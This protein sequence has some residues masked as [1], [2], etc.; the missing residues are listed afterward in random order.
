MNSRSF[1][2]IIF[3]VLGVRNGLW[4]QSHPVSPGSPPLG[5]VSLRYKFATGNIA[6]YRMSNELALTTSTN[7]QTSVISN[8]VTGS[9]VN[10]VQSV[11]SDGDATM[12]GQLQGVTDTTTIDGQPLTMPQSSIDKLKA[13][14][15]ITVS[16]GGKILSINQA[17]ATAGGPASLMS[18]STFFAYTTLP[19]HPVKINDTWRTPVMLPSLPDPMFVK[20]A[21][22]GIDKSS[23]ST[24]AILAAKVFMQTS[25]RPPSG[26]GELVYMTLT[27]SGK[28]Y[29]DVNKGML[30]DMDLT[31]DADMSTDA[32]SRGTQSN[33]NVGHIAITVAIK[34]ISGP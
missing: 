7:G 15:T 22:I 3:L 28:E 25:S 10:T 6:S 32:P 9:L 4:A 21:L 31:L 34:S 8:S 12:T 33:D 26:H 27:G 16:P 20:L 17:P 18:P 2:A 11:D 13:P 5:D 24:V 30:K 1:Y 14:S 29:F 23:G 19:D